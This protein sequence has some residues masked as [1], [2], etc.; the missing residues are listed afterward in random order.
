ML[1]YRQ[2]TYSVSIF[3]V[4]FS[5]Y[6]FIPVIVYLLFI[7]VD[8][9][10]YLWM[11]YLLFCVCFLCVSVLLSIYLTVQL[12]IYLSHLSSHLSQ[13]FV[14]GLTD[15]PV[16]PKSYIE[17]G[18]FSVLFFPFFLPCLCPF[19]TQGHRENHSNKN[20]R[21]IKNGPLICRSLEKLYRSYSS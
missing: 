15:L 17:D 10:A 5:V 12:H 1:T 8:L 20:K 21:R 3:F 16:P 6:L 19:K 18:S 13:T 9:H 14:K 4:C 11:S 7:C 2:I